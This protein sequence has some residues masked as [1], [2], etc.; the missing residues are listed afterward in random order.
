MDMEFLQWNEKMWSQLRQTAPHWTLMVLQL[1]LLI[2]M[3]IVVI[4]EVVFSKRSKYHHVKEKLSNREK[5]STDAGNP[6]HSSVPQ[7]QR[8]AEKND[9]VLAPAK[10]L[11]VVSIV[12]KT[13]G[14]NS[15]SKNLFFNTT[16][17][18]IMR[19]RINGQTNQFDANCLYLM[20]WQHFVSCNFFHSF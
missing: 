17:F 20:G 10:L 9:H 3:M 11:L 14:V 6:I 1:L 19:H 12:V 5:C 15:M 13:K 7:H 2:I 8:P 16:M 4:N 18:L